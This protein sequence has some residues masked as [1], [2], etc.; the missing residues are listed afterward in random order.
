MKRLVIHLFVPALL[1]AGCSAPKDRAECSASAPCGAGQYCAH[2]PDGSVCWPDAVAPAV[3]AV[4]VTCGTPCLRAG[5]LQVSATVTDDQELASVEASIPVL[6]ETRSV[7]MS[8]SN[9]KWVASIPLAEWPFEAFEMPVAVRVMARDAAQNAAQL[10]AVGGNVPVVTRLKG[11][12]YDA[13]AP[14]TSPAVLSDGTVVFGRTASSKQLVAVKDGVKVWDVDVGTSS[15]TAAPSVG[16]S[17]WVGS[18]DGKLYSFNGVGESTGGA[19]A[20]G[21]AINAPAAISG[22]RAIAGSQA[23]V[24]AAAGPADFCDGTTVTAAVI[25]GPAVGPD[26]MIYVALND[27]L[28]SFTLPANGFLKDNWTGDPAPAKPLLSGSV[29]AAIAVDGSGKILTLASNGNL[30]RTTAAGVT[31][32]IATVAPASTGPVVLSDGSIVVGD[33]T[34]VLKRIAD[35]APPWTDSA[36]LN[37]VPAIPLVLEAEEPTLLV[38]TSTGRLYAVKVSDGTIAWSVKLSGTGQALQPANI[39]T[40][41]GASTSTA[42]IGGADGKLYAVIVDG[43]LDTAAPWPKAFHDPRNT[44]NAGVTP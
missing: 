28:D 25:H 35:S 18:Q 27:S 33:A 38:P 15:I 21:E 20:T 39:F 32:K 4:T 44:S 41:P 40:A 14:I 6:S 24:V 34:G 7:P 3:Q 11:A 9:G 2:T 23:S 37:G 36:T 26:G 8:P 12:P 43:H 30:D 29:G 13:G 22:S 42:Y 16:E 10:D 5:T 31:Q 1:V 17:I 19:C